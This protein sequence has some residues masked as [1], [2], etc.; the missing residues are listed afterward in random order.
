MKDITGT[1]LQ[2]YNGLEVQEYNGIAAKSFVL[3]E[4]LKGIKIKINRKTIIYI[5]GRFYIK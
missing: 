1:T 5:P 4:K 3:C 2:L